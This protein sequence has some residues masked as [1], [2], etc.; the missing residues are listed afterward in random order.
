MFGG[1]VVPE[2]LG[3]RRIR[4][5]VSDVCWMCF[6]C[7]R[8][9]VHLFRRVGREQLSDQFPRI[10]F[11]RLMPSLRNGGR[12]LRRL[13][14]VFLFSHVFHSLCKAGGNSI[15]KHPINSGAKVVEISENAFA[16]ADRCFTKSDKVAISAL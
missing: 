11:R 6:G 2:G 7:V 10:V 14:V 9:G 5:S 1:V 8:A 16:K 15:K 3:D 12:F 4:I 13:I